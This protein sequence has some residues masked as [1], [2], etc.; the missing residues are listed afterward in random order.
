MM[1]RPSVLVVESSLSSLSTVISLSSLSSAGSRH[2]QLRRWNTTSTTSSTSD[3]SLSS[4]AAAA[5]AATSTSTT[6][7]IATVLPTT[8]QL[9]IVA[10]RSAIPMIGFGIM[11]NVVMITAGEAIDSTFGVY[12]GFSTMV[13]AGKSNIKKINRR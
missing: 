6:V 7:K 13:A 10:F 11:D 1:M 3:V 2:Q 5:A 12:F 9:R 4:S 8:E